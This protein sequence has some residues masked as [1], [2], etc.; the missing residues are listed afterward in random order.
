MRA[1]PTQRRHALG[2]ISVL[3]LNVMAR[4][5][6]T[7]GY[8]VQPLFEQFGITDTLLSAAEARISIP[9]F[10]RLGRAAIGLTNN[11]N[12]GLVMGEMTRPV[13]A[14]LPGLAG[15]SA[16]T[17]GEG[18][19]SILTFSLLNS[20]NSR[21]HPEYEPDRHRA[22]FYS[23]RPYN[24]YNYFVVDSVMAGWTQFLRRMTGQKAVLEQ[25]RIEYPNQGQQSA[26]ETW[27]DCPVRFGAEENSI[28]IRPEIATTASTEAQP[29]MHR[30]LTQQCHN[31]LARFRGGWTVIDQVREK[32]TPMLH[33]QSPSLE[34]V[35]AELGTTPWTLQR[36]IRAEGSR[37][38]DLLDETRRDLASDYVLETRLNY[39]EIAWILGF[40]SPPAFHKAYRRWFATSPGEHRLSTWGSRGEA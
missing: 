14:G 2:N 29:T 31:Q 7:E 33:G 6:A 4:A 19:Q 15:M 5:V 17:A 10:M 11:P 18:L 24:A 34:Q 40:S 8:S 3:Y 12:L 23:I 38:R 28:Q 26:F 27:F 25:V 20:R 9:R 39:A 13:D 16:A 35:A 37:F 36:Q 1:T 30:A 21:G 22:C 32:L